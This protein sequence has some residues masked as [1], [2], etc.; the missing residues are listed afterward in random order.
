MQGL[1]AFVVLATHPHITNGSYSTDDLASLL[2]TPVCLNHAPSA[3]WLAAC[4]AGGLRAMQVGCV[5]VCAC[6]CL[7]VCLR[8]CVCVCV[9]A[10]LCLRYCDS[11]RLS[12]LV[13]ACLFARSCVGEDQGM[14]DND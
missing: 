13:F 6:V 1:G 14:I 4:E 9:C 8:V 12:A 7:C 2:R 11:K 10:R 3:A 5:C